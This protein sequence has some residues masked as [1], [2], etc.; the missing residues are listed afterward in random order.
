MSTHPPSKAQLRQ[1]I[2]ERLAELRRALQGM[3]VT[4]NYDATARDLHQAFLA[5]VESLERQVREAFADH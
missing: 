5:E 2:E 4:G 3:E 1:R